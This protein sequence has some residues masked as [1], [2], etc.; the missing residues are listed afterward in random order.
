MVFTP[1]V[2]V[3]L[4]VCAPSQTDDSVAPAGHANLFILVPISPHLEYSDV[5]LEAYAD[6]TLQTVEREMKVENLRERIVYKRL[7]SIKDFAATYNTQ[8]GTALGLAHTVTQTAIFRPNNY[9]KKVQ[10][11][12]YAGANTNPGIGMP[13]CLISA[14]LAYKRIIGD[15]SAGHLK[16]L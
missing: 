8:S 14:E 10:N 12:F 11:L 6:K 5:E 9:S 15:K 1:R 13:I 2:T 7:F 4:Y 16:E 3:S